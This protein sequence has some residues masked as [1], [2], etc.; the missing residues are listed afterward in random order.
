MGIILTIMACVVV[1]K[2]GV[3]E[4]RVVPNFNGIVDDGGQYYKVEEIEE[5]E[6]L[7]L[8]LDEINQSSKPRGNEHD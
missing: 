5:K 6:Y 8:K 3:K 2:Y 1:V 7:K 4:I